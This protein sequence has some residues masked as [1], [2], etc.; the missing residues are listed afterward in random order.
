MPDNFLKSK[1]FVATTN[2]VVPQTNLIDFSRI[3]AGPTIDAATA[4]NLNVPFNTAVVSVG[5]TIMP[6]Y[7]QHPC[8]EHLILKP[9]LQNSLSLREVKPL[10]IQHSQRELS[11]QSNSQ[12]PSEALPTHRLPTPIKLEVLNQ[13]LQGYISAAYL[14]DGFTSGFRLGYDG[15]RQAS[16]SPNLKSCKDL[17]DIVQR[18]ID[19]ELSAG[20]IRGPFHVSPF[21]N[22]KISPIGVVLKKVP[23][24][25]RLIHHLSY[26]KNESVNDFIDPTFSAVKY[27]SFDDA[28][29]LVIQLGKGCLMA[30]TD[31]ESAF[32]LIPIHPDDHSLLGFQFNGGIYY[33]LCLPMGSSSSCAIFTA[34][35]TALKWIAMEKLRAKY[36]VHILDDFLF[37]G[38]A[39]S[40]RCNE[41][42]DNFISMC[43]KLGVPI[44]AEKTER[45]CTKLTFMGLELDSE[46]MVARLP[47]DKLVKLRNLLDTFHRKRKIKL[48]DLQSLLGLLNFCCKV[49]VPGRCFL[50]RLYDLLLQVSNPNFRVTLNKE[51]RRDL[52]AWRVFVEQFN[53]KN[54][55]LEQKWITSRSIDLYTDAAGAVG[56]GAIYGSR[57]F[58][59]KW[60]SA[61]ENMSIAFKELFPITL[62]LEIWGSD[63]RNE[64]VIIHSDNRAVVC[65]INKQTSKDQ[66]IMKLVRRLVLCCMKHNILIRAEHIPGKCN[67]LSDCLS[68]FQIYKFH[69]LAPQMDK[70][71]VSVPP[72]LLQVN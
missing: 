10:P 49:V 34:F 55:L 40:P 31:I 59:G 2:L 14:L 1:I 46:N 54:L 11:S 58:N 22:L 16:N 72:H 21:S 33:D 18:K 44:K 62:A 20:R 43:N 61:L 37:L 45:A 63:L 30:K 28:A 3:P 48:K 39:R 57:W 69:K 42:L 4:E 23:G 9:P 50:R 15:S 68:R 27:S 52:Q 38:P 19:K 41:D 29:K 8:Q 26:P 56:F 7:V 25:Y 71:P 67:I 66:N 12:A 13:L 17:P 47:D 53:G 35:S 6:Q 24:E 64:C 70:D 36:V 32:R 5:E 65:I 51:S 60:P